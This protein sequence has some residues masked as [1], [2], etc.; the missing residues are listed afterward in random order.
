MTQPQEPTPIFTVTERVDGK[1]DVGVDQAA[2]DE[3]LRQ[4]EEITKLALEKLA[5]LGLF[6]REAK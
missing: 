3:Y 1:V 2:L 4:R 6:G 5:S